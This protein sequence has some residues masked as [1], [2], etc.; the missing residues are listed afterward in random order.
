MGRWLW[1]CEMG[2][3]TVLMRRQIERQHEGFAFADFC[4]PD[5][6]TTPD[7]GWMRFRGK[8]ADRGPRF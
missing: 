3:G 4:S 6:R 7:L 1:S 8:S 5:F 2:G